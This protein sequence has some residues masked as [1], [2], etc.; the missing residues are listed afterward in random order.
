MVSVGTVIA[1]FSIILV[2]AA[3]VTAAETVI[4]K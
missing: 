1:N 4:N 2:T 3:A